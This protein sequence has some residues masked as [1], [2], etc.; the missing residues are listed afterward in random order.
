MT[1]LDVYVVAVS[2]SGSKQE[3]PAHNRQPLSVQLRVH[4]L[5]PV[6][7]GVLCRYRGTVH[8]DTDAIMLCRRLGE[9]ARKKLAQVREQ[10]GLDRLLRREEHLVEPVGHL[11]GGPA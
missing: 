2:D 1:T 7:T 5:H 8:A 9:Q 10:L 4:T 3:G 6:C 11:Y